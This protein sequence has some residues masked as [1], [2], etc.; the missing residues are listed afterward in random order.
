MAWNDI[1]VP[2]G[3]KLFKIQRFTYIYKG[4]HYTIEIDEFA[5]GLCTAHGEHATDR[6]Y[7][8]ESVSGNSPE[9]CLEGMLQNIVDRSN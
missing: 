9:A 3:G 7:V 8:L 1:D 2:T 5:D 4:V 6:N